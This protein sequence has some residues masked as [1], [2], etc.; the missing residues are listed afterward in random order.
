MGLS[1]LVVLLIALG[2]GLYW[3]LDRRETRRAAA[4][5][6]RLSGLRLVLASVAL[7]VVLF[8][9]GCAALFLGDIWTRTGGEQYVDEMVV[10]IFAGPPLAAGLLVWWLAM[11]RG[12]G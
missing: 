5:Q 1:G 3:L 6:P 10:L 9:G 7:L 11:R 4:G 2:A 12:S 8:A